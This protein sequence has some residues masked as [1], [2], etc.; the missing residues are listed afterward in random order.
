VGCRAKV[1][2]MEMKAVMT[3]WISSQDYIA[4]LVV[5]GV[6]WEKEDLSVKRKD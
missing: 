6:N 1:K 2:G 3:M 5:A 4:V